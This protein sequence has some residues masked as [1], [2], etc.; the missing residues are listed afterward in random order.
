[1][2]LADA[3]AAQ[4][5]DRLYRRQRFIY[6]LT[7]RP[8]LLGRT[9]LL[10]QLDPPADGT[11]IEIGCGT[12]WNLIHAARRYPSATF[13]GLDVSSEMLKTAQS[14]VARAGLAGRIQLRQADATAFDAERLFGLARFDRVVISYALSMISEWPAV[15]DK[16]A[17]LLALRGELHIVDFGQCGGLPDFARRALFAWLGCFSVEPRARLDRALRS[18]AGAHG[19][20]LSLRDPYRGYAVRAR[21]RRSTEPPF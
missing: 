4:T 13:Y 9:D 8:Y 1:M 12:A 11:V 7:R 20:D 6:D 14:A 5:M 10:R 18:V 19:L 2:S 15:I 16:A 17:R 21:L 3:S